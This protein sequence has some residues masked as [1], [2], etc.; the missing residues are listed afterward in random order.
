MRRRPSRRRGPSSRGQPQRPGPIYPQPDADGVRRHRSGLRA[1]Q[2]LVLPLEPGVPLAAP[3]LADHLDD[4]GQSSIRLAGLRRGPPKASIA[5]QKPP[6]PSPSSNRPPLSTSRL[7]AALASTA[8]GRSGRLATSGKRPTRDVVAATMLSNV[9]VL[10]AEGPEPL[11]RFAEEII[12]AV[13]AQVARERAA[14]WPCCGTGVGPPFRST[15]LGSP[16]HGAARV[17]R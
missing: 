17:L 5:S 16:T 2:P 10:W 9:Q 15:S 8:G 6:A 1:G 13:R 14:G 3:H 12:A 7:A 11:S 4:L